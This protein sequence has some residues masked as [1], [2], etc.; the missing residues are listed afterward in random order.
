MSPDTSK[1]LWFSGCEADKENL[2][3]KVGTKES[4]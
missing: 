1:A 4:P 3:H 2:L